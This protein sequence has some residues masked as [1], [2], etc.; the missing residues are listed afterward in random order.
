MQFFALYGDL[1]SACQSQEVEVEVNGTDQHEYRDNIFYICTVE[2]GDS[3]SS[4]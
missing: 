3:V 4:C 2:A 1:K